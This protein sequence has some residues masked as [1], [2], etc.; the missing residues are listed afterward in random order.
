[1]IRG[2][3]LFRSIEGKDQ[4]A[5]KAI[6]ETVSDHVK[7]TKP[8]RATMVVDKKRVVLVEEW[9]FQQ[10]FDTYTKEKHQDSLD[11]RLA[12]LVSEPPTREFFPHALHIRKPLDESVADPDIGI[13]VRQ[14]TGSPGNG[15]KL[16][17]AQREAYERQMPLEPGC[18]CC[19]ILS[20][21][22]I[23]PHQVR[24]IELWKTMQDFEFHENSDWHAQGE[25]NVVPLV[26]DMDCDFV[27]GRRL[28]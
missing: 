24:I 13:L 14:A 7:K 22:S 19:I 17:D 23:A 25:A 15:E 6:Q 4:Q 26:K 5:A 2:V 1:M 16:R 28:R 3:G 12:D 27:D 11:H 20:G 10:E 9:S 21:S 18:T 8:L